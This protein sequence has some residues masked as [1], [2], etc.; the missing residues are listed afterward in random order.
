MPMSLFKI[1]YNN[2]RGR[3]AEWLACVFLTRHAC[4]IIMRNFLCQAGELD[5]ISLDPTKQT[6]LIIE[7]RYRKSG[8]NNLGAASSITPK[9]QKR[10]ILATCLFLKRNRAYQNYPCRFDAICIQDTLKIKN[11]TWHQSAFINNS[12]FG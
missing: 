1:N 8:N 4:T 11:I 9:K 3:Y 5:I 2:L 12:C 7:V 6:L 10:I